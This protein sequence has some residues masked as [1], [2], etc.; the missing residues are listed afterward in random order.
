MPVGTVV[1]CFI[2]GAGRVCFVSV[3]TNLS[4]L[5]PG[6]CCKLDNVQE[7]LFCDTEHWVS[8]WS[9]GINKDPDTN[10]DSRLSVPDVVK[11]RS[12]FRAAPATYGSTCARGQIG[13]A[14]A[15]YPTAVAKPDRDLYF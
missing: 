8:K 4:T 10:A 6:T 1:T 11:L 15:T 9:S 13:A 12:F 7:G 5:T 14:A 3:F 2:Y